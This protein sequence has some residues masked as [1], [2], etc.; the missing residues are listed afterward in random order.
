VEIGEVKGSTTVE[1]TRD[2]KIQNFQGPLSVSS[3]QG[4]ISLAT[5]EKLSADVK[6]TNERGKIRL[7]IPEN[8]GFRLDANTGIGRVKV[9]G[10]DRI[11]WSRE[12]KSFAT[13]YNISESTP[14]VSLRSGGG[15]IRLQSSGRAIAGFDDND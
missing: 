13:G 7:S 14:Q 3:R 2:V 5:S 10:F 8:S 9:R 11:V 15:E 6:A 12:E 4:M 1:A